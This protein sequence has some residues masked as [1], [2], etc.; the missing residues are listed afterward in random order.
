M[1]IS[2]SQATGF[3]PI[4]AHYWNEH[5]WAPGLCNEPTKSADGSET[6]GCGLRKARKNGRYVGP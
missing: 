3:L 4:A 1:A 6:R 2:F 5:R